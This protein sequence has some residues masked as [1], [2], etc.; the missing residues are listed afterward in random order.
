MKRRMLVVGWLWAGLTTMA[1][2]QEKALPPRT[3][4]LWAIIVG[5]GN[6]R[7]PAILDSPPAVDQALEVLKWFRAAGW[8]ESHQLLLRDFGTSD[9][10]TPE[11]PAPNIL[12]TRAN[13]DWAIRQWLLPK[14]KQGDMVVFYYA[15]R[16]AAVVTP[17]GPRI[18]PRVDY[19]LLPIDGFQSSPATTGWSLDRAVDDCAR[20][21][22]QVVCWLATTVQ[23]RSTPGVAPPPIG[24]PSNT[25]NPTGQDWLSRL[26]R[27][28]GVTAWLAADRPP[29]IGQ[30]A[31]PITPFT[32]ALLES[33]GKPNLE[34]NLAACLKA[35]QRDPTLKRQGFSSLGGV[36][37]DLSLWA[38]QFGKPVRQPTPE[39]VLQVG[40][41][42][43]ITGLV[44]SADGRLLI[45]ASMDSTLRVWSP[46]KRSLLRVL[47]GQMVGATAL[48]LSGNDRWLISGGGRGAVLVHDLQDFSLNPAPRQPHIKGVVQITMLPDRTHF[49]TI[50]RDATAALW[51][52]SVSPL[53]PKPWPEQGP[54]QRPRCL[55]V[56]AGGKHK[57]G[58]VAARCGD[59][60][61]RIFDAQG[62]GGTEARL[63]QGRVTALAVGPDAQ[64]LAAGFDDGRVVI[65]DVKTSRADEHK[66]S[67]GPVRG[68]AFSQIGWLA[69]N[70]NKGVQLLRVS[71]EQAKA[72]TAAIDLIDKAA[73]CL[74]ISADGRYL[75]ICTEN[76]GAVRAWRLD[77]EERPQPVF[78]DIEAR[79]ST[80]AFTGDG[81]SL[82]IGG[83]DGSIA[84]RLLENAQSLRRRIVGDR[85]QQGQSSAYRQH[86][87]PPIP[88]LARRAEP[89]PG[90]GPQGPQ[91]RSPAG[92]MDVRRFPERR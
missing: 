8:D 92:G 59:G 79:A 56:A 66:V 91:L 1:L 81:R 43:K 74:A 62:A 77:E 23:G 71:P 73:G 53:E 16:A 45:S 58:I 49:V 44:S 89:R 80:V 13:L 6:Y 31:D 65:L 87:Q 90:L 41:A 15:G 33:L 28:P 26:A 48:A 36:P 60:K 70:H 57:L 11:A 47:T 63:P 46:R 84:T 18:E 88:A 85:R 83:Y 72:P 27:W 9:P 76:I 39:M 10:G 50:D 67:P 25:P 55:E 42:D 29:G 75:A 40:H 4:Q 35:L 52:L 34:D 19:Y 38:D 21:R 14:A 3:P 37:P 82:I 61:V 69:V 68:L 30:A 20:R 78:D 22:I 51:D 32:T 2:A 24:R 64:T 7:D 86:T 17:Q 54:G 5:V 12:P